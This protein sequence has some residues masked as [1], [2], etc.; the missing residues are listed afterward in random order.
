[1]SFFI[2]RTGNH[3]T[4]P[5][6]FPSHLLFRITP[7][8]P[9]TFSILLQG[10]HPILPSFPAA[11]FFRMSPHSDIIFHTTPSTSPHPSFLD[12]SSS[13]SHPFHQC[14]LPYYSHETTSSFFASHL[15]FRTSPHPPMSFSILLP[16]DH[17]ILHSFCLWPLVFRMLL[18][19]TDAIFH[20]TPR[21]SVSHSSFLDLYSSECHPIPPMSFSILLSGDYPIL[22][23]LFPSPLLFRMSPHSTSVIFHTAPRRSPHPSILLSLTSTLQGITPL[24][25]CHFPYHSHEITQPLHSFFPS[26][27]LFRMSPHSTNVII[28]TTPWGSL[29][30]YLLLSLTST[31]QNVTP[32][33]QSHFPHY[34]QEINPFFFPWPILFRMS[35][36][37]LPMLFTYYSQEITPSSTPFFLHCY[38]S[39]C[40][41]ILPKSFS[42]LLPGDQPILL[43]LTYTLQNVTPYHQCYLHTTLRRSPHPPLLFF[44]HCYSSECHPILPKSF[45]TLLP[46]DQPILLSLTSLLFR[47][48]PHTTNVI[49]H[50][51]L[52]RSPHA[53]IS[54][55]F[56][57][58]LLFRIS[59]HTTNVIFHTTL[60]R[61]PHAII[62]SFFPCPLQF[63]MSSHSPN[64]IF[65][66][67]PL[68]PFCPSWTSI[69]Q[70][71][72]A[73]LVNCIS[74]LLGC[75]S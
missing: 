9:M 75:P 28:H 64:A 2:L 54:S 47:M 3:H 43:S 62:S 56:P 15:L 71:I 53:I 41:P 1:M 16:G 38:S 66:T 26:H 18:H 49:F 48:S 52:R 44:L 39:E 13:E 40:H 5:S 33:Y 12:F 22:H 68:P 45:S 57:C 10:Y 51:T 20:S 30:P 55:F 24:H 6:F 61:S 25:Q 23:S 4:L 60:R 73:T 31:L 14:H 67:S 69:H 50:T 58:P 35:P 46:G 8:S 36:H 70:E 21:R 17:L 32:I 11:L 74:D 27:L 7:N 29:D 34:S 37:F 59:P 65:H 72:R 63:R 19:P 42:T